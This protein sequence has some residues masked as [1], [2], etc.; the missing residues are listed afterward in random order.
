VIHPSSF[1]LGNTMIGSSLKDSSYAS[2]LGCRNI[3]TQGYRRILNNCNSVAVLSEGPT[4]RCFGHNTE[5]SVVPQ[6]GFEGQNRWCSVR[7]ATP[8][9]STLGDSNG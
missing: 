9:T 6:F 2:A 5:V 7:Y 8:L 3:I 4:R 1:M